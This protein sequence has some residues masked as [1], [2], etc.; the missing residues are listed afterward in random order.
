MFQ[1][2]LP[3]NL[4]LLASLQ[5]P[6]LPAMVHVYQK[7]PG[8]FELADMIVKHTS[9]SAESM[10]YRSELLTTLLELN[11]LV[12]SVDATLWSDW[13]SCNPLFQAGTVD[14]RQS[15]EDCAASLLG[16]SDL[17]S[18]VS[19]NSADGVSNEF[20]AWLLSSGHLLSVLQTHP[21]LYSRTA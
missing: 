8:V 15:F 2:V 3:S 9:G 11:P 4:E 14:L 13:F 12:L 17:Q 7:T 5:L 1:D 6:H 16:E 21:D 10:G 20:I 18:V 19:S